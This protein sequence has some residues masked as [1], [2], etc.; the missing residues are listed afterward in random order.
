MTH[1]PVIIVGGGQ[2]GLSV[3]WMLQRRGIEHLV[4]EK[5]KAMHVWRTRR[6]T[7]F[8]SSR[9]TGNAGCPIGRIAATIRT[10]S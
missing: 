1:V 2:A 7:A 10:A 9:R 4:F 5:Q 3:S 8:V 6:W